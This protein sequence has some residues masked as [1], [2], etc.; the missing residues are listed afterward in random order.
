MNRAAWAVRFFFDCTAHRLALEVLPRL[1]R[2]RSRPD[3]QRSPDHAHSLRWVGQAVALAVDI[4]PQ[5]EAA[6]GTAADLQVTV[7]QFTNPQPAWRTSTAS[8]ACARRFR[9]CFGSEGEPQRDARWW[10]ETLNGVASWWTAT[11]RGRHPDLI[12]KLFAAR[13]CVARGH[14]MAV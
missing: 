2:R 4:Y 10:A 6:C 1:S 7:S 5:D 11:L 9:A 13:H 12:E 14:W 3:W 8:R